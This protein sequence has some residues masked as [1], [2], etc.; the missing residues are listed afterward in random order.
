MRKRISGIILAVLMMIGMRN[1]A[2]ATVYLNQEKPADWED[3]ERM[4]I[5][6]MDFYQN[7]AI[8]IQ[9]AGEVMLVDGG[10]SPHW[11]EMMQ[12][13]EENGLSH[14]NILFNTHPHDDHIEAQTRMLKSGRLTA[15][16]FISPFPKEYKLDYQ[17]KMVKQLEKSGIPYIQMLPD[18]EITLG[19]NGTDFQVV[20]EQELPTKVARMVLYR[21]PEGQGA[22]E[23]SG[24]LWVH[25]GDA[26]I[27]LPGDLTGRGERWMAQHYGAEGLKSDILKSP[28]HGIVRMVPEFLKAVDPELTVITN[29][30]KCNAKEQLDA[31]GYA[32]IWT[33]VGNVTLETDGTDWYVTQEKR[34]F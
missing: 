1:V 27:L 28:H 15:D 21:Y 22:N 33:Y 10:A 8:V 14:V 17:Q 5:T 11:E 24:V 26:T 7:D 18:E 9:C 19:D 6:I 12:W 32:N 16:R 2:G 25:Y 34:S 3:R 30:K 23:L 29:G 13:L 31:G 4:V 20:T